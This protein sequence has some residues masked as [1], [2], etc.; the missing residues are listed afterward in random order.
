MWF[1]MGGFLPC[2]MWRCIVGWVF[3][4]VLKECIAFIIMGQIDQQK[5]INFFI[6]RTAVC[7]SNVKSDYLFWSGF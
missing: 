3:A 1:K 6:F 7:V 5:E 4:D 2:G